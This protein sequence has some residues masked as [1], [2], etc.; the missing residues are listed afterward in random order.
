MGHP[1]V[2]GTTELGKDLPPPRGDPA[3]QHHIDLFQALLGGLWGPGAELWAL[4]R[5]DLVSEHSLVGPENTE[6]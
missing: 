5:P 3:T 2:G 4:D 1:R 6:P